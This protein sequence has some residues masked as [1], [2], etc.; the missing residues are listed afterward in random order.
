[1]E[2]YMIYEY[3][4]NKGMTEPSLVRKFRDFISGKRYSRGS[5][6]DDDFLSEMYEP[7]YRRHNPYPED[8]FMEMYPRDDR[9]RLLNRTRREHGFNMEDMEGEHFNE[10]YARY[11]VSNMYHSENGRKYSGEKYDMAKAREIS[12]RYRGLISPSIT[13]PDIYV[14]INS[15]YHDYAEL[16]KA[17]FGEEADKRI[18]EAAI[19]F[20]FK[21][22]DYK[23][24]FKLGNYFKEN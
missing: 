17:W 22:S 15:Q 21:D 1:M 7:S 8:N 23:D 13:V 11:L 4:R 10:T 2:D 16:F 14:A 18:I 12:E 24:G 19:V 9:R 20:W 3:L 6:E 5:M